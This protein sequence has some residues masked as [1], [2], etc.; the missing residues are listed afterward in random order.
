MI[1]PVQKGSQ[2]ERY[3]QTLNRTEMLSRADDHLILEG[4]FNRHHPMWDEELDNR[5][6]TPRALEEAGKLIELLADLNLNMALPKGQLT[7]KHLVTKK[8]SCPDNFWCTED[9][10]DLIVYDLIV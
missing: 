4:D 5:I 8:Y 10:Y 2:K 6:F 7:L 9:I 3:R 1:N